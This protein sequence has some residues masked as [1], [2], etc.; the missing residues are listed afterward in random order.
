MSRSEGEYENYMPQCSDFFFCML[1]IWW[2]NVILSHNVSLWSKK[3]IHGSAWHFLI[4]QWF[5]L[6]SWRLFDGWRSNLCIMIWCDPT[7]DLK[8]KVCQS[9]LYFMVQYFFPYR[10]F[11]YFWIMSQYDTT[12]DLEINVGNNDL[13]FWMQWFGLLSWRHFDGWTSYF[14]IMTHWDGVT[15]P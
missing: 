12:F 2:V 4:V 11:S 15:Q 13:Y 3:N 7:V 10:W 5:F 1:T 6:I 14:H 9:Y 8:I